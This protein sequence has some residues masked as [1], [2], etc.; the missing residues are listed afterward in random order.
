MWTRSAGWFRRY[1][2][3]R[4]EKKMLLVRRIF[5]GKADSVI[6]LGIECTINS[7]NLIKIITAIFE[8]FEIL[9]FFLM[10]TTLN[11]RGRGKTKETTRD[12]YTRTL[13]IVF[14]R[15]RSIGL[16]YTFGDGH[17]DRQTDRQTHTHTHTQFFSKTFL[18]CDVELKYHKK[19]K[20]N[21]LTITILPSLLMSLES[22]N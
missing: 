11:F 4:I 17:T 13:Y 1:V 9:N 2:R 21:L 5:S 14:E 10:W 7:Q 8:K 16:G 19:S 20:S 18:D 6:L 15:D 22:K 12:I 3:R